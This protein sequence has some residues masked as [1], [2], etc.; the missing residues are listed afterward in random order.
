MGSVNGATQN[1]MLTPTDDMAVELNETVVVADL[2]EKVDAL[3]GQ[4]LE[5]LHAAHVKQMIEDFIRQHLGWLVVWGNACGALL[6]V[7]AYF[8]RS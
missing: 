6:G 2:R 3:L 5:Q 4:K 7:V 8:L 1:A